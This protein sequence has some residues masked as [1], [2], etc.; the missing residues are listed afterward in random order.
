MPKF[1]KMKTHDTI[2]RKRLHRRKDE[3]IE[4]RNDGQTLFPRTLPATG[5]GPKY[6]TQQICLGKAL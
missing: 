6:K 5:R 1:R 3:K 4:G 2:P